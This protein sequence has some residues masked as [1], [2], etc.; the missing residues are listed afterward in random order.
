MY[1]NKLFLLQ[2]RKVS[3]HD[4]YGIA[5]MLYIKKWKLGNVGIN[6]KLS[7]SENTYC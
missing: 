2:T 1:Q 3:H 4:I 7:R 5:D 6:R